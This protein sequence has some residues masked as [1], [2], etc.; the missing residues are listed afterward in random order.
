MLV[1]NRKATERILVGSD[2]VIT[3]VRIGDDAVRIGVDAPREV[4]I[5]R[6]ELVAVDRDAHAVARVCEPQE[7][8]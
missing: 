2:V 5:V 1:L 4:R 7:C 3:V 6:G 8:R